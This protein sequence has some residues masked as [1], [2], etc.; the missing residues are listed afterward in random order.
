MHRVC[1]GAATTP[2]LIIILFWPCPQCDVKLSLL[3]QSSSGRNEPGS[4]SNKEL[5]LCLAG[6]GKRTNKG[7]V[8]SPLSPIGNG[9][10]HLHHDE[11]ERVQG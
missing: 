1:V 9:C 6:G 11:K 3:R 4:D 8:K 10:R 2:I 5:H 7:L